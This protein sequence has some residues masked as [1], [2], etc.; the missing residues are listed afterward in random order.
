M[1]ASQVQSIGMTPALHVVKPAATANAFAPVHFGCGAHDG[2]D[3]VQVRHKGKKDQPLITAY[4]PEKDG[5]R[6]ALDRWCL[7]AI[8]GYQKVTR[9]WFRRSTEAMGIKSERKSL[10][11]CRFTPSCSEYTADAIRKYGAVKG[12]LKGAYRIFFKCNPFYVWWKSRQILPPAGSLQD[13]L[14]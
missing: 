13:P 12:C 5:K 11:A 6:N 9:I 3:S 14:K 10:F 8:A 2:G 1:V 4:I 7:K